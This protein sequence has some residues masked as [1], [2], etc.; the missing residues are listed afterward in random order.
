MLSVHRHCHSWNVRANELREGRRVQGPA[1]FEPTNL[2]T[3]VPPPSP[4]R[5]AAVLRFHAAWDLEFFCSV[6]RTKQVA[7][8]WP[9]KL[10]DSETAEKKKR[11]RNNKRRN[12]RA[13][14]VARSCRI[15]SRLQGGKE[16]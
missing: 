2:G 1:E 8:L 7:T 10:L 12:Q 11:Q 9:G 13:R 3:P 16:A 15:S 14:C 4:P 5:R 6:M